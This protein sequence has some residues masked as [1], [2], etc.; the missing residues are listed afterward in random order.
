MPSSPEKNYSLVF[1]GSIKLPLFFVISGYVFNCREGK[2]GAFLLNLVRKILIPAFLLFIGNRV[3][4][5]FTKGFFYIVTSSLEFISGEACWYVSACIIAEIVFFFTLKFCKKEPLICIVALI[6]CA[7]GFVMHF[8]GIGEF[9]MLNRAFIAQFFLLLGFLFKKHEDFF[10]KLHWA[11]PATGFL[12]S[13]G[14]IVASLFLWK[15]PFINVHINR[16]YNIPYCFLLIAISC[17]SFMT[18]GTKVGRISR[19]LSLIGRHTLVIYVSHG[20]FLTIG[21]R[22]LPVVGSSGVIMVLKSVLLAA[23]AITMCICTSLA[24]N[25]ICPEIMGHPRKRKKEKE[26]Q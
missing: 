23:F 16:Y 6:C 21:Q 18:F 4:S 19:L 5:V 15:R 14:M 25:H 10:Q 24:I 11:V 9:A 26:K 3:P 22:V 7:S 8:L 1:T 13:I 2:L 20:I 17:L 12:I